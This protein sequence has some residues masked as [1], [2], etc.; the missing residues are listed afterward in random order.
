MQGVPLLNFTLGMWLLAP[1]GDTVSRHPQGVCVR[2]NTVTTQQLIACGSILYNELLLHT[3]FSVVCVSITPN[4]LLLPLLARSDIATSKLLLLPA[5]HSFN[6]CH[7]T[8]WKCPATLPL[9]CVSLPV[10]HPGYAK[11]VTM[12][13][14]SAPPAVLARSGPAGRKA[15]VG[16]Y[17][18][19]WVLCV[20]IS[21]GGIGQAHAAEY[22]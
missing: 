1:Q 7:L 2:Q 22:E 4:T 10:D 12:H 9:W 17:L 3:A 14:C 11:T 18:Q 5:P 13:P 6:F 8:L 16:S 20:V 15:G 21:A 19:S